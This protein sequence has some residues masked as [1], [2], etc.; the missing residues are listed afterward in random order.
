[1][2]VQGSWPWQSRII[3]TAQ[4]TE[5]DRS[6]GFCGGSLINE[7]WVVTAAHCVTGGN[8]NHDRHYGVAIPSDSLRVV[9][10]LHDVRVED[11]A[12]SVSILQNPITR[13]DP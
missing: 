5:W 1:M 9:L 8:E 10:G 7:E 2:A 11:N 13:L 6:E 12:V 4:E 3:V